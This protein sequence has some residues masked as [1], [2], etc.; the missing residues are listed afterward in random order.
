MGIVLIICRIVVCIRFPGRLFLLFQ[1]FLCKLLLLE[2]ELL[3]A[4]VELPEGKRCN[5]TA[6]KERNQKL[7]F[8]KAYIKNQAIANNERHGSDRIPDRNQD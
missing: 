8:E 1:F 5:Q 3:K 4:A 2:L 7:K 6:H